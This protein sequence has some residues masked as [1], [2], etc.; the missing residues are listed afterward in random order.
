MKQP[1][2]PIEERECE[3]CKEGGLSYLEEYAM[4]D[5]SICLDC[6]KFKIIVMT[7]VKGENIVYLECRKCEREES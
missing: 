6:P 7:N 5:L 3:H 1:I 2:M 4:A